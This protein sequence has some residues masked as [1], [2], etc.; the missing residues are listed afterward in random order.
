M[1]A[2]LLDHRMHDGS[3]Q[4]AEFPEACSWDEL[5][6]HVETFPG[7]AVTDYLTDHITEMWLDFTFRD[8]AFSVNNQHGHFWFFVRDPACPDPI[9][10]ALID[11]FEPILAR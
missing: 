3:R 10:T 1:K 9:L 5:R 7:A 4:F 6:Q 11:H 2:T 8:H